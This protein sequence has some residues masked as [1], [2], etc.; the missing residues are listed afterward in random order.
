MV[1]KKERR[2]RKAKTKNSGGLS[3]AKR[4]DDRRFL[5]VT[6]YYRYPQSTKKREIFFDLRPRI[7]LSL[8]H[9]ERE[10]QK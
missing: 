3:K 1:P 8:N 7:R 10:R 4:F 6:K 9:D 5:P 2:F